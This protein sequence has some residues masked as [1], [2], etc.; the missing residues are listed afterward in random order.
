M[1]KSYTRL[2]GISD[3]DEKELFSVDEVAEFICKEGK[4]SDVS[5]YQENG[6]LLLNTFGIFI[7]KIN[8][9][10]YREEL[11]KT[12]IPMQQEIED[13]TDSEDVGMGGM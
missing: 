10:E 2:F 5:I 1:A 3:Y 7:N 13:N 9:M 8:D 4:H 11:L 12:L 6:T